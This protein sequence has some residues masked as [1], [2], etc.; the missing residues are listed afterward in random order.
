MANVSVE[1]SAV[2]SAISLCN[3]SMSQF[4]K[5]SADLQKKYQNAGTSWKDAKYKQLGTIVTECSAT[6]N[7]PVKE[8]QDCIKKLENLKAIIEEYERTNIK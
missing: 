5:A 7:K 8:L 3:Q 6:L 1:I 2:T 4:R